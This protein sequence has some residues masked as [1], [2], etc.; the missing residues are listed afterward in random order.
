[1]GRRSPLP[2]TISDLPVKVSSLPARGRVKVVG[3]LCRPLSPYPVPTTDGNRGTRE[4]GGDAQTDGGRTGT[5]Q[6]STRANQ[7]AGSAFLC[8]MSILR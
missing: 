3:V 2:P 7:G 5:G 6:F 8:Q 1:M 4:S